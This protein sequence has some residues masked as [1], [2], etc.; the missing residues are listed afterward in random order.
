MANQIDMNALAQ[1]LAAAL[2]PA[3]ENVANATAAATA[4]ATATTEA[5]GGA[6]PDPATS[7]TEITQPTRRFL[8]TARDA[9]AQQEVFQ[10]IPNWKRSTLKPVDLEKYRQN[11]T[12][13]LSKKFALLSVSGNFSDPVEL[14]NENVVAT[15][16]IE[17]VKDHCKQYGMDEVFDIVEPSLANDG[18]IVDAKTENLF[19]NYSSITAKQIKTSTGF[20]RTY[21]RD[22]DLQNL[23]WAETFLKNCCDTDL[24]DKMDERMSKYAANEKGGPIFF[25][26]MMS[27]I[28]TLTT[29]AATLMKEKLFT[30]TMQ[31]FLGENV[32]KAVTLLRGTVKRLEMIKDV[33]VDLPKQLIRFFETCSVP[34]FKQIFTTISSLNAI[35]L[36]SGGHAYETD[37]LLE[38]AESAY[39]QLST[40]WNVPDN[41]NKSSFITQ[42]GRRQ[43]TCWGCGEQGHALDQ[44]P[45]KT[46]AE[47]KKIREEHYNNRGNNRTRGGNNQQGNEGNGVS[48]SKQLKTAPKQGEK[49]SKVF[50][51]KD[52]G[53][54]RQWCATCKRWSLTHNTATH[55]KK[56]DDTNGNSL[57]SNTVAPGNNTST[58]GTPRVTFADQIRNQLQG[59]RS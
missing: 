20:Y 38:T 27:A 46:D 26:E 13:G 31:D 40:V 30:L 4:A 57:N 9:T 18:T 39:L 43:V 2:G 47:K 58:G 37:T 59:S 10:S 45:H 3:L 35:P 32:L 5:V 52:G 16:L 34:E 1:A 42:G 17:Q 23:Q 7:M 25:F 55:R 54:E 21:G 56:K 14:L 50:G 33:P 22:Y 28:L 49:Q 6:R 24:S 36:A 53:K 48:M 51:D 8:E 11:A 15:K 44:C 41:S 29:E 19:S 12:K